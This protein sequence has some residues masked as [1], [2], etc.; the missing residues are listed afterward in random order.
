V[1]PLFGGTAWRAEQRNSATLT[2][3]ATLPAASA[4]ASFFIWYDTETHYDTATFEASADGTT[5]TVLGTYN[6]FGGRRWLPVSAELPAGTTRLRWRY[7]TDGS[8]LG[9]GVYVDHVLAS[10]RPLSE[11][12]FTADGWVPSRT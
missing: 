3:T 7:V 10:G 1:R 4:R 9:R 2:L 5:W 6:G 8:T 11:R 12:D